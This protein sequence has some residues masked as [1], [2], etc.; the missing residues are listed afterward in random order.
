MKIF[1]TKEDEDIVREYFIAFFLTILLVVLFSF[2]KFLINKGIISNGMYLLALL[3][4]LFP[5]K[6]LYKKFKESLF[7][8]NVLNKVPVLL[9]LVLNILGLI[10]INSKVNF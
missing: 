6:S 5:S 9:L 3:I 8:K 4:L 10:F 1:K 2:F 7:Y